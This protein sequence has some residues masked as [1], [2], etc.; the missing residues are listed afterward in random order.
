MIFNDDGPNGG[1]L[2]FTQGYTYAR[3]NGTDP[4]VGIAVDHNQV[5]LLGRR[6]SELIYNGVVP[7][8]GGSPFASLPGSYMDFGMHVQGAYTAALQNQ[9][10]VWLT[11]DRRVVWRAWGSQTAPTRISNH[12]LESLLED[13][14]LGGCYAFTLSL[15]GHLFYFLTVPGL[16]LTF[17]YDFVTSEW[18]KA[19]SFSVTGPTAWR[20]LCAFTAFGNTYVGDS[21][22]GQIGLLDFSVPTE[23][24]NPITS[25]WTT[26]SIYSNHERIVHR[27][28]EAVV[29][30]GQSTSFTAGANLTCKVSDDSGTTWRYLPMRS[31]GQKG[32][33]TTRAVWWNLGQSRDRAYE[34][35][36]SDPTELFAVDMIAELAGGKW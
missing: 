3:S 20:P 23:Y 17:G 26:Q 31:L 29:T 10:T 7:S 28:L 16:S 13:A 18:F 34:F 36:L 30:P 8:E 35:E 14:N 15:G 12:G 25:K 19:T 5:L 22:S 9:G 27:R 2:T 33:Y 11:N 21:I 32:A 1:Q 4:I 24:G 6:T